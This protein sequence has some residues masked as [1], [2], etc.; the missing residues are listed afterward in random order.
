[1]SKLGLL[2][3]LITGAILPVSLDAT[4]CSFD[5]LPNVGNGNLGTVPQ[6][7]CG[8][9]WLGSGASSSVFYF[10]GSFTFGSSV[11][12]PNSA[13]NA[14]YS[15]NGIS[16]SFPS[17]AVFNGFWAVPSSPHSNGYVQAVQVTLSGPSGTYTGPAVVVPQGGEFI[18]SNYSQPVDS[19][20]ICVGGIF[21]G[22]IVC[23]SSPDSMEAIDDITYNS[24]AGC[25]PGIQPSSQQNFPTTG[26]SGSVTVTDGS[27]CS[28][29]ATSSASWITISSG[30]S[31]TGNG[32]VNYQVAANTSGG[33]R[34]G[35][36]T[37]AGLSLPIQQAGAPQ[38]E[39]QGTGLDGSVGTTNIDPRQPITFTASGWQ[40]DGGPITVTLSGNGQQT[41]MFSPPSFSGSFT[42]WDFSQQTNPPCS[43]QV[44]ATQGSIT[45]TTTLTGKYIAK[46]VLPDPGEIGY[47]LGGQVCA[48]TKLLP[49]IEV[50][51]NMGPMLEG[52]PRLIGTA[53]DFIFAEGRLVEHGAFAVESTTNTDGGS[54]FYVLNALPH[55]EMPGYGILVNPGATVSFPTRDG[56]ATLV[57]DATAPINSA[58]FSAAEVF[59][60][61]TEVITVAP[62]QLP[63]PVAGWYQITGDVTD[64]SSH[65]SLNLDNGHLWVNGDVIKSSG[66]FGLGS[67]TATGNIEITGNE[68]FSSLFFAPETIWAVPGIAFVAGGNIALNLPSGPP[69]FS[70]VP[71]ALKQVAVG[72]DGSVWGVNAQQQIFFYNPDPG[73][74]YI[75]G[76]LTQIAAGSSTA[77]WGINA[78][79]QIYRWNS[80]NSKW[81]NVPGSLVQIAVGADGDV[82][83]INSESSIYHYNAQTGFFGQVAGT[84]SQIKVGSA[85]AVYGLN[86]EGA[87]Y[88]YNPG[89]GYF[90][91]ITGTFGFTDV[92]VG[93]DGDLWAVKNNLAYHYDVVHNTMNAAGA[94]NIAQLAVGSGADVFG[95]S[96]A[97]EIFQWNAQ[98][99]NWMQ[100]PGNL[101]SIAVGANGAVWGIN[102]LQQIFT[103]GTLSHP[104]QI[105]LWVRGSLDQ[106]S[107]GVDGS[108]WGINANTVEFFDAGT[109]TFKPVSGAPPLAQ[110]SVSAGSD[111]WGID[112]SGD[113]FQYD[114][115]TGT[116]SSIP[117][118]LNFVQV[119]ANGSVWG[120]NANGQTYTYDAPNQSWTNIPGT[121][122]QLSVGADGTVWGLNAQQQIYRFDSGTQ[123]WVNIPGAL[124]QISVGNANTVWGV[125]A[126]QQVYRY[127][128]GTHSWAEIPGAYLVNISAG[129][130]GSVWGVNAGGYLYRWDSG[131]QTFN[132][133]GAGFGAVFVGNAATVWAASRFAAVYSWF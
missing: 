122:A 79:Q 107:V 57:G 51:T 120:I 19:V 102:S 129:F 16:F 13:P 53:G 32:T 97:G 82:W 45:Q 60:S 71:G 131:S 36:L 52:G 84:L 7:Y 76:A 115:S 81:V 54:L 38:F 133:A 55:M 43:T 123:S 17:P 95:L 46:V 22:N 63:N 99:A 88:W 44:T 93:H 66:L 109:Q 119:G 34:N 29:T 73:W 33:F 75:P 112:A 92:E 106:I 2:I 15:S 50:Q 37:I 78:Q 61:D 124:V 64:D 114:G 48:F 90:Q 27:G 113:I 1:M 40:V 83:G 126:A 4:V 5:D 74:T 127:D 117:G 62:N 110:L 18:S 35:S 108:V 41:Q 121:L 68:S 6:N 128:N 72:A 118:N 10:S 49:L 89:T 87:I 77:I 21:N 3:F 70:M 31:G 24:T 12:Y 28:W 94:T 132:F 42:E 8:I 69:S 111:V 11:I 59:G 25:T 91:W 9:N 56:M 20:S 130:D 101:T 104:Y 116:W 86:G 105:P 67:I 30:G 100:I 96:T 65:T 47:N 85:G 39:V 58:L 125:N 80:A 98:S 26:G 14:V 103:L 23:S